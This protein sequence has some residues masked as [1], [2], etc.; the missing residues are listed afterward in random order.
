[1][2]IEQLQDGLAE[3][4]SLSKKRARIKERGRHGSSIASE[5]AERAIPE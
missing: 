1:M 2:L 4:A 5:T 3:A